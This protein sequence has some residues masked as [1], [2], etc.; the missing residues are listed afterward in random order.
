MLEEFNLR[1]PKR[2]SR[3]VES[4]AVKQGYSYTA[5]DEPRLGGRPD[6]RQPRSF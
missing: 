5:K 1:Q 3:A 2:V 6:P 4:Y